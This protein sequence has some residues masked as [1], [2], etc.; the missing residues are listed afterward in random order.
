M[1]IIL[2]QPHPK[3]GDVGD[4]VE[5]KD[6]FARN[7]LIPKK[8]AIPATKGNLKQIEMLK[9]R[10]LTIEEK[11]KKYLH[12]LAEKLARTSVDI[13]VETDEEDRPFGAVSAGQIADALQRQGFNVD[14]KQIIIEEPIDSL[15]V[16]NVKI[17]LHPEIETKI[18]LWVLKSEK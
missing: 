16:Y 17:K 5:V 10:K 12:Q 1:K 2:I 18:R 13:V 11:R 9:K 14:K 3:L 6:G 15:G 8:F 4:I 7:Y